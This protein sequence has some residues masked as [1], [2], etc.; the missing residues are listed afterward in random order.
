MQLFKQYRNVK[1]FLSIPQ[2]D[3]DIV[4]Y[5]EGSSYW[6]HL[7]PVI[8][9]L[10]NENKTISYLTSAEN[11]PGLY[12]GNPRILSFYIGS[13]IFRTILFK[14]I[15]CKIFVMTMPD[16]QNYHIKRS[17][18]H[19][20]YVYLFHSICSTHMIYRPKAFDSFDTIFCVGPH[21]VD[22]IKKLEKINNLPTKNLFKHGYGKL[23]QILNH[24]KNH[25]NI[26]KNKKYVHILI[27]PS[28]GETCLL[29]IIGVDLIQ[30]LLDSQFR[31]ILKPHTETKRL[32]PNVIQ[33][34]LDIFGSNI[35]F[36]YEN[37]EVSF[38]AFFKSDMMITDWSGVAFEYAFAFLKPVIFMNT[39][40][41]VNNPDWERL[42]LT[43]LEI[44]LRKI[45]GCTCNTDDVQFISELINDLLKRNNQF[46]ENIKKA[47]S[48][49]IYNL[50]NS[51][52]CGAKE[53]INIF[54]NM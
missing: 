32:T 24:T 47:R 13:S 21:H 44:E 45:I 36:Q 17:F 8:S 2:Q 39:P 20:H 38:D 7:K 10:I 37:D 52:V 23:D 29:N 31:V 22:E 33:K 48:K 54:N 26:R 4:F 14:I 18:H 25:N 46:V 49:Y 51:G 9:S 43:P 12:Q 28:W 15:N 30:R 41:K 53:I 19:V 11:D 34:I 42:Q 35:N 5:S 27:A 3:R 40:M 50:N 16:L 6:P 1:K